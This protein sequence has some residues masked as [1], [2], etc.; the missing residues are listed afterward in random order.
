MTLGLLVHWAT[1]P[2]LLMWPL[3]VIQYC[4]LAQ[5]EED[6]MAAEFGNKYLAYRDRVP[7]FI[8]KLKNLFINERYLEISDEGLQNHALESPKE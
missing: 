1:I 7:M 4:R 6:E 2:L 3:L 8:P 5:R